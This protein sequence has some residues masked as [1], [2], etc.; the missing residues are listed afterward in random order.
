MDKIVYLLR[1]FTD[2]TRG[3][4]PAGAVLLTG[5]FDL[6]EDAM[7]RLAA[8]LNYSETAFILP[9]EEKRFF[10]RYFTPACQV[11]VCGHATIASFALL[12][13]QGIIGDG[14]FR[15]QTIEEELEIEVSGDLVWM[16]MSHPE[17]E[18]APDE[19]TVQKLC[20]AYGIRKEDLSE[21]L[22]PQIVRA[23]I[24]DVHL[25]VRDRDLLMRARQD[26]LAVAEI[27]EKLGAA[28]VHM[29]CLSDREDV[30]AHCSNFAPYYR[31]DEE[32]AT[33]TSNAGLTWYLYK[34][35]L[36][37]TGQVNCFLQGEHM[38]CPSRVFTKVSAQEGKTEVLVGGKAVLCGE[39]YSSI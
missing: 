17:L 30:T 19:E 22:P 32:C 33:G 9:L 24:R 28:G 20:D 38:G 1:A 13:Q 15:L 8:K 25:C 10:I 3:G 2:G 31:I 14:H 16:E 27:S 5:G 34:K 29:S 6:T 4:N 26:V 39:E 11:P 12:R 36:I 18:G 21:E 35:K 23:G 37:R 7:Q